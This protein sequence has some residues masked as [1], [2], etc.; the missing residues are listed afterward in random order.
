M[1]PNSEGVKFEMSPE[2]R[3]A[4]LK[5]GIHPAEGPQQLTGDAEQR[6]R[7]AQSPR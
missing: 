6:Q 5:A 1:D 7:R 4:L 3:A 2:L